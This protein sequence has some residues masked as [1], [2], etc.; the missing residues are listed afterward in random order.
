MP[1]SLKGLLSVAE[2]QKFIPSK[3][4]KQIVATNPLG[5]AIVEPPVRLSYAVKDGCIMLSFL[6][7]CI[8]DLTSQ[9]NLCKAFETFALVQRHARRT[10]YANHESLVDSISCLL[11]SCANWK[12]NWQGGRQL[13]GL[14]VSLGLERDPVLVP[15]LVT[16]YS[17]FDFL[18]ETHAIVE[19]V[20]IMHPLPWNLLISA[21]VRNEMYGKA[22]SAYKQMMSKGVRPDNFTYPSVLKA[23]GEQSDLTFGKEV[24]SSIQASNH[25]WSLF[26]HNSL[27]SMYSK[28]GELEVARSLFDKM[29]D[30]DRDGVSWNAI[31]GGYALKGMWQ[32]AIELFERM[33]SEVDSIN[34]I[35]WNTIA[36]CFLRARNFTG[37][38]NLLSRMRNFDVQL[39]SVAII[40]GLSACS[41]IGSLKLGAELHG[42]AIRNQYHRLVNVGNALITMY[43]RCKDPRQAYVIFSLMETKTVV[44]WNSMISGYTY[45]DLSEE[46]TFIFREM[47]L[48][49]VEPNYVTIASILPICA[50]IANLRHG[51]EFHSYILKRP[52][53]K[54]YLLIWNALVE[55]YA[56][57]GKLPEA[58]KL[59]DSMSTKDEVTYTSLIAAYGIQGDGRTALQ[60]FKEMNMHKIKPDHVTMVAVLSACSHSGLVTEGVMLFREMSSLYGIVPRLEHFDCMV[61]L[62]GRAGL[63][64]RAKETVV[65]M[66]YNPTPA[67]WATLL[68]ACRI[69][70]NTDIG[71]WAATRLLEMKPD[72]SGYYVLSANMYADAGSWNKLAE[73]RTLMKNV[74]VKKSPGYAWVDVGS[75]YRHFV[76]GGSSEEH[77][78][79]LYPLLDG[80]TELMK[81]VGCDASEDVSSEDEALQAVG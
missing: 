47:L 15:K 50:R 46:A 1:S 81:D 4:K 53:F 38:L 67:M 28:T 21:Y 58:I 32:E 59:F 11:F 56:R 55:M 19:D 65:T 14:M 10:S 49:R 57:S 16:F 8:K 52:V 66:P 25:G 71:E 78:N 37:V 39:D 24:H 30:R 61:D 40:S 45:L 31:I 74:G 51:K 18:V 41:H 35:T 34:N 22:L 20:N 60:L 23:C 79:E 33:Q 75:G 72:N 64:N 2:I 12:S 48:A 76:V 17:N 68:G 63:L 54:D 5:T 9:G 36:G 44:S 26:V 7:S 77:G 6:V 43:S 3:W 62:F 70:G 29:P 27:I 73:V 13:H 80:M 42:F 69:H